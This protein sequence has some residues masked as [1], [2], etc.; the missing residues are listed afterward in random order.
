MV[1]F[2]RSKKPDPIPT[3][4]RH[5]AANKIHHNVAGQLE[6]MGASSLPQS[7]PVEFG[8]RVHD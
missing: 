6:W 8:L 4:A 5:G 3:R 2:S 7:A 1:S